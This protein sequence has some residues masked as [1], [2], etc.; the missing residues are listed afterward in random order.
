MASDQSQNVDSR[1]MISRGTARQFLHVSMSTTVSRRPSQ[2]IRF[3]PASIGANSFLEKALSLRVLLVVFFLDEALKIP[4]RK[5]NK[6]ELAGKCERDIDVRLTDRQCRK[7]QL[8]TGV[9]RVETPADLDTFR[10]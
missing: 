8:I 4:K 2:P 9:H 7:A 3:S 1:S 5:I 6:R 10:F